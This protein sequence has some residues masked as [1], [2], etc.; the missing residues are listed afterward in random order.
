MVLPTYVCTS[1]YFYHLFTD[2]CWGRMYL[3]LSDI[4]SLYI[5]HFILLYFVLFH[6]ILYYLYFLF[7]L[8]FYFV[9]FNFILLYIISFYFIGIIWKSGTPSPLIILGPPPLDFSHFFGTFCLWVAYL[10][11]RKLS[12]ILLSQACT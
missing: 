3:L 4:I 10:T 8:K 9:S 5:I 12:V 1:S 11:L 2:P 6:F 7:H